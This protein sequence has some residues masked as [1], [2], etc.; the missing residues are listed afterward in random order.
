MKILTLCYE[1]PPVG[2][3]GGRVAAQ[4]SGALAARGHEVRVLTSRTGSLPAR[5]ENPAGVDVRRVFSFRRSADT[6]SVP[7]MAAYIAL[8]ALPVARAVR[9]WSPDVMHVHFAVPTGPVAWFARKVT[10]VPYVL[11][12]HLGDVPGGAPEQ[13]DHLFRVVRPFTIPIWRD[14][15]AITAVSSHVG[16]LAR[17]AYDAEAEVILNGTASCSASPPGPDPAGLL[18]LLFVGRMSVQ[19]NPLFLAGILS[20]MRATNWR[21]TFV[22]DGPLR[23]DLESALRAKGLADK[24]SFRGWLDNTAVKECLDCSDVLLVPSLSEGLPVAG[25]EAVSRGLAIAGSDIPGLRDLV[26]DGIN[27]WSLPLDS[28]QAW[29]R[30]LDEAASDRAALQRRQIESLRV[31]ARFDLGKITD[32]YERVLQRAAGSSLAEK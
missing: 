16:Q 6:C 21:M 7:E 4:I 14:A 22:G 15:A 17:A 19:K 23:A 18:R 2:G 20:A 26:L 3:G 28:T 11:T 32:A 29:G 1:Y 27:G 10:G 31:A 12:V 13:T 25:I 9:S 5:E 24:C 30:A 8:N